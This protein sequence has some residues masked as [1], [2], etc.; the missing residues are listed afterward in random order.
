MTPPV[1]PLILFLCT[2]NAARSL[3]AEAILR[4][5]AGDRFDVRSAG[6]DPRGVH[7]LTRQVLEEIGLSTADLRSK[8]SSD[9]LGKVAVRLAIIVCDRAHQHCPRIYPFAAR[10]LYWPFDDP[11]A[12]EGS[13]AAR[14]EKFRDVRDQIARRV[15]AWL[16]E[17]QP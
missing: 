6:M 17:E 13:P 1:K 8:P 11:A 7:P 12:F 15:D 9:F 4:S 3:M 5:Q 14:L 10:T 16:R 2:G